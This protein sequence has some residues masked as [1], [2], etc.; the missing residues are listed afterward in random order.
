MH[1]SLLEVNKKIIKQ[2]RFY[3]SLCTGVF[4]HVFGC[5]RRSQTC[6]STVL[7]VV[8]VC[9]A[10]LCTAVKGILHTAVCATRC[11]DDGWSEGKGAHHCFCGQGV[12]W[13][14]SLAGDNEPRLIANYCVFLQPCSFLCK[15][16]T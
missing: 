13:D 15:G 1:L 12:L 8:A 4:V 16:R 6:R 11:E 7:A 2:Y 14:F 5:Y 9:V 3:C 10:A